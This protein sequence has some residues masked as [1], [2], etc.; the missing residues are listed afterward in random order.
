MIINNHNF[1]NIAENKTPIA[2]NSNIVTTK[3]PN[4]KKIDQMGSLKTSIKN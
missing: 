1:L 3:N 2:N 4:F